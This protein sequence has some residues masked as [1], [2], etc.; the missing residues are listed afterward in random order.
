MAHMMQTIRNLS[1]TRKILCLTAVWLAMILLLFWAFVHGNTLR[2]VSQ[3]EEYINELTVQRAVSIDNL[4]DENLSFVRTTAFLY[5]ERLD[6]PEPDI[7]VIQEFENETRFELIRFIDRNGDNYTSQGKKANLADRAYFQAGMRGESGITY[8]LESRV[9]GETQIGFY[10]PVYFEGDIIGVM[11]GFF[12]EDYIQNLLVYHLFGF[13][14]DGYLVLPDGTLLGESIPTSRTNFFTDMVEEGLMT[15]Q[16]VDTLKQALSESRAAGFTYSRKG[17]QAQGYAARLSQVD[18]ILIRCFPDGAAQQILQNANGQ[19]ILVMIG[20]LVLFALYG[21]M[22]N[23][24]LSEQRNLQSAL[25]EAER[26]NV[27]KTEFLFNMSHD[28]R[29]PMN[30]IIG[31]TEL[32]Q[33]EGATPEEV[34]GYVRKTDAAS[35][36]LLSLINDVLE[37]SRIE[38]GKLTLEP[39]HTDLVESLEETEA[40]FTTQMKEKKIR[41]LVDTDAV[42]DRGVLC[43]RDRLDRV[44][45]NL[46]SNAC[47][48]TPE[49]GEIRVTLRQLGQ[50][51]GKGTYAF[52][53]RDT[54]IG[55]SEAFLSKLFQPFERERTSTVSK[56]QGTGLGLSITKKIVD[57]M[58]GTISA[59]SEQGKGTE[60]LVTLTFP[61]DVQ[62]E[63]K[64]QAAVR[65]ERLLDFSRVRI[66]LAEDNPVNREIA[67]LVIQEKGFMLDM[68]E[69]GKEAVEKVASSAPGTYDLILMDIQ[70]PEM[71]GYAAARAIRSLDNPLLSEIPILAMTANAFKEDVDAAFAAGMNGHIA[72]PLDVSTMFDTIEDVLMPQREAANASRPKAN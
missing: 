19:G 64:P 51:E 27:A 15:Q 59:T 39:V 66:L 11:V 61:L 47:K 50:A 72:K 42:Q 56:T 52:S 33:R 65:S 30:A 34:L 23:R 31:Y 12:G 18:W 49:G 68:A 1:N 48:F 7:S 25:R 67:A 37:M 53:V 57:L 43:D 6:S 5:A 70:M 2:I 28:L 69:N 26:A 44:L 16:D 46:V 40:I 17:A 10:T 14:G 35:K 24:L 41:F 4:L 13:E 58:G 29:T 21:V 38:S 36:H 45:L 9:T 54:G 60:F 55:M 71:D 3:N 8:V 20:L 62:T 22:I 63:E 32:A